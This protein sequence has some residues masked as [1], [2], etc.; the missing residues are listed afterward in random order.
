MHLKVQSHR[1]QPAR[2]SGDSTN[3]RLVWTVSA[4]AWLVMSV[5]DAA[6]VYPLRLSI[7]QPRP[8][9][10]MLEDVTAHNLLGVLVTPGIYKL[11]LMFPFT[12]RKI[13]LSSIVHVCASIVFALLNAAWHY[14]LFPLHL[15]P[16][17]MDKVTPQLFFGFAS[18][19]W[20]VDTSTT[21]IPVLAIAY[22][23]NFYTRYREQEMQRLRLDAQLAQAQ[24]QFLRSQLNPHFLFNT[25]HSITSL[26]HFDLNAADKMIAR[27]SDLLRMALQQSQVAETELAQEL[28]FVEGYLDIERERLGDRLRVRQTVSNEALLAVVPSLLLQPLVENAVI[29]GISQ[30]VGGG[31]LFIRAAVVSGTLRIT[32]RNKGSLHRSAF[33]AP[34]H[35]GVGIRNI[36]ER[37][38]QMYGDDHSFLIDDDGK[39]SVEVSIILPFKLAPA[40]ADGGSPRSSLSRARDALTP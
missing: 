6:S 1:E 32:V 20:F 4:A 10:T 9:L 14:A 19:A 8:F 3:W 26:M 40:P 25:L 2:L 5:L 37:L 22:M 28:H 17:S 21:Y 11:A 15:S 12:P 35:S 27:L 29:H 34:G 31:E 39:G 13:V 18:Y 24:L 33:Q 23:F 7:H 38:L 30:E 36:Q 16:D